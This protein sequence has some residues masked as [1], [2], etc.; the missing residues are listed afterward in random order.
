MSILFP[1][2]R[3]A[4]RTALVSHSFGKAGRSSELQ[5]WEREEVI[6]APHEKRSLHGCHPQASKRRLGN[7]GAPCLLANRGWH[8][9]LSFILD[10]IFR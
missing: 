3:A 7:F 4:K 6:K 8:G 1:V 9:S 5:G 10:L 2:P